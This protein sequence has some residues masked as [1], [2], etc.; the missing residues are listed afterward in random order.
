VG[1]PVATALHL[2]GAVRSHRG[3]YARTWT[4]SGP[5]LRAR[6]RWFLMRHPLI[7]V[8]HPLPLRS[9]GGLLLHPLGR[10]GR[11]P[12]G[13]GT[14]SG[15]SLVGQPSHS[16]HRP[17][18]EPTSSAGIPRSGTSLDAW[19]ERVC[20]TTQTM[21]RIQGLGSVGGSGPMQQRYQFRQWVPL[22]VTYLRG[23]RP[24][25]YCDHISPTRSRSSR[26]TRVV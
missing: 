12:D 16:S 19:E 10:R 8:P 15:D 6:S 2:G 11:A 25:A 23:T 21:D 26:H 5:G 13:G 1:G 18:P 3:P 7:L 4:D 14:P 22:V 17:G 20:L 24:P 9:S